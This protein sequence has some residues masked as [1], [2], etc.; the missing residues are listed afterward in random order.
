MAV[1]LS[2]SR[3][4]YAGWHWCSSIGINFTI[5]RCAAVKPIDLIA[6]VVG[7]T[8]GM[9]LCAFVAPLIILKLPSCFCQ[10][11]RQIGWLS[12]VSI[13]YYPTLACI[14]YFLFDLQIA[15]GCVVFSLLIGDWLLPDIGTFLFYPRSR[16]AVYRTI[17]HLESLGEVRPIYG[18]VSVIAC[19]E[20]QCIISLPYWS[21]SKPP[22][23]Q[24]IAIN[25]DGSKI[26]SL[27]SEYVYEQLE[28][29][30]RYP[31]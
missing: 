17:Q 4:A 13:A 12:V 29:P 15:I 18:M 16:R 19:D 24:F 22:F 1:Y 27:Q 14:A 11:K 3:R 9:L 5:I 26:E 28:V 25:H 7:R 30:D 21:D 20:S 2:S 10:W 6:A 8:L 31:V 23:R